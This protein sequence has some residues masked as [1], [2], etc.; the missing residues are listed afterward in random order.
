MN[1]LK[2]CPFCS[3]TKLVYARN[4]DGEISGIYCREC[5]ALVRF[6]IKAESKA[7]TFGETEAKWVTAWNK[8]T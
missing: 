3:N 5:K 4:L 8:R 6:P 1:D 7:E 2:P